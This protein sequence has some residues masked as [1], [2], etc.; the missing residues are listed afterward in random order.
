MTNKGAEVRIEMSSVSVPPRKFEKVLMMTPHA[1][2]MYLH[3]KM[4]KLLFLLTIITYYFF[5]PFIGIIFFL[6]VNLLC[7][8][9]LFMPLI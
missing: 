4:C 1:L 8:Y 5:G 2:L 9:T 6:C 3:L 7:V